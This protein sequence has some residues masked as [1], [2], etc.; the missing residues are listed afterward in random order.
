MQK[1]IS[2]QKIVNTCGSCGSN[3]Y[4]WVQV[5]W[6]GYV[7][8]NSYGTG[9]WNKKRRQAGKTGTT[10]RYRRDRPKQTV[11]IRKRDQTTR[12][13]EWWQLGTDTRCTE[14]QRAVKTVH[15]YT[16]NKIETG[17]L[18]RRSDGVSKQNIIISIQRFQPA[19]QT[20]QC[21]SGAIQNSYDKD[22]LI[23]NVMQTTV[24]IHY[25]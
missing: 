17:P 11:G 22:N 25:L 5:Q 13:Y 20:H 16:C 6:S 1:I 23:Q 15:N 7:V 8:G 14:K 18:T 10:G 9:S 21:R 24:Q 3:Q 12:T 2:S 4:L 19:H